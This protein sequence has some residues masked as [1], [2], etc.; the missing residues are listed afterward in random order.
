MTSE[1]T[2]GCN[3]MDIDTYQADRLNSITCVMSHGLLTPKTSPNGVSIDVANSID[4]DG[5]LQN[6]GMLECTD[7]G[8]EIPSLTIPYTP[9]YQENSPSGNIPLTSLPLSTDF[10][11]TS[12]KLCKQQ[13]ALQPC[14]SCLDSMC[15]D[16]I[17]GNE[18]N[19][20]T[21]LNLSTSSFNSLN[22]TDPMFQSTGYLESSL[23]LSIQVEEPSSDFGS[24]G[25]TAPN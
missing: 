6:D 10:M 19:N 17:S 9:E 1:E 12:S 16:K 22:N 2:F 3:V 8:N 21:L 5:I 15:P 7:N 24:E 14:Y 4:L 13:N 11:L 20:D 23:N 25:R 18:E